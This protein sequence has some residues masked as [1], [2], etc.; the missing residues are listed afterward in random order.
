MQAMFIAHG[1]FS[2]AVKDL[3]QRS[4]RSAGGW[5]STSDDTYIMNRLQNVEIYNLI[6]K[7]LGISKYAASTNGTQGF[8]DK[9]L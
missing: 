6:V 9:Y 2:K 5:H 4:V 8:W 1:P 7:L 3:H